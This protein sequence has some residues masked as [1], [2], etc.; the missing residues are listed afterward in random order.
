MAPIKTISFIGAG[1]AATHLANA[2][3]KAG[4]SIGE[5]WSYHPE[6]AA[7]LA[8]QVGAKICTRIN[9]L[10]TEVDL[11][12][13]SVKDDA[14][15]TVIRQLPKGI[16]SIVHTSGSMEMKLLKDAS[17]NSG[18]FYPLQ[19]FNKKEQINFLEIPICIE[20][21]ND[22]FS[23][24]LFQLARLISTNVEYV[25][26]SQRAYLHIAA[27]IAN[28]FTNYMYSAAYDLVTEKK[29]PFSLLIPLIKNTSNRLENVDPFLKQ[30]GPAKRSDEELIRSHLKMLESNPEL[31]E[32]YQFI[33]DRIKKKS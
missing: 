18:V 4:I 3:F 5:I 28:N 8:E 19:S 2:F 33:S 21:S 32:L 6:N 30:T 25:N 12:I 27:V 1:N 26:S 16:E 11:I 20:A 31:K 10:S 22:P 17:V 29:I 15:E 13:I 24:E 14:M 9:S 23:A 7:I